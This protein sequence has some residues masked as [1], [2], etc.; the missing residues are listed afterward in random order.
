M[1][2]SFFAKIFSLIIIGTLLSSVILIVTFNRTNR[3][4]LIGQNH[5]EMV[6]CATFLADI[7]ELHFS[8]KLEPEVFDVLLVEASRH[9][10]DYYIYAFDSEGTL[11]WDMKTPESDVWIQAVATKLD[12]ALDAKFVASIPYE[13]EPDAAIIA[14]PTRSDTGEV[15]GAVF[16]VCPINRISGLARKAT[17][18]LL[19]SL[20][21]SCLILV[22]PAYL[23]SRALS[24]PIKQMTESAKA[25]A[26][27]DF[28][29]KVPKT[30]DCELSQLGESLS[31]MAGEL[32]ATISDLTV[33]KNRLDTIMNGLTEGIIASNAAGQVTHCNNAAQRLLSEGND[34]TDFKETAAFG[35]LHTLMEQAFNDKRTLSSAFSAEEGIL[36]FTVSPLYEHSGSTAGVVALIKDIT[37]SEQLEATRREY[38]AN[39]SHELRTPIAAIRSLADALN[40]GLIKDDTDKQRYYGYILK[41][42]LRLSRLIDD[43]LDLSRLQADNMR[44][45]DN[46]TAAFK[47]A[48]LSEIA[49]EAIAVTLDAHTSSRRILTDFDPISLKT[50]PDRMEQLFLILLDNAFRHS[51]DGDIEFKIKAQG[52]KAVISVS[53]EGRIACKDL[54]H[55]FERFYKTDKSHSGNGTGLGLAIAAEIVELL[56]GEIFA[57]SSHGHVRFTAEFDIIN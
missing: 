34:M 33:E 43:L 32:S 31:Y 25:I 39:V 12:T 23:A 35:E 20:A 51:S 1:K 15:N 27:G 28:S 7:V 22:V 42:S 50:N 4:A 48:L 14:T 8:E 45:S 18:A 6:Y 57:E 5:A 19:F 36:H 9:F 37:E 29:V 53:N 49:S 13:G 46:E 16:L 3:R 11:V 56:S 24:R 30:G 40:D 26:K 52:N 38:V 10:M 47:T 44:R 21:I 2:Y 17:L 54:P 55:L 41:E